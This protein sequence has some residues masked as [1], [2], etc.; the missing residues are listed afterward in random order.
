MNYKRILLENNTTYELMSKTFD[1][2]N[3]I[4]SYSYY[5]G[6]T[7]FSVETII[8]G[9]K[10]SSKVCIYDC[11]EAFTHTIIPIMNK[12]F[13]FNRYAHMTKANVS[14][15]MNASGGSVAFNHLICDNIAESFGLA[16]FNS[17]NF[18]VID[19]A[20]GDHSS[21]TGSATPTSYSGSYIFPDLSVDGIIITY[22]PNGSETTGDERVIFIEGNII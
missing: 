9:H 13:Q 6:G 8:T 3:T 2:V 19:W 12:R 5:E 22:T 10:I 1:S 20:F 18:Q 4:A 17:G 16:G 14:G 11:T 21:P 7:N 15:N